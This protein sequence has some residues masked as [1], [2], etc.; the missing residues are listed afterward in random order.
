MQ[1][2]HLFASA[3]LTAITIASVSAH[4][5][6]I[7]NQPQDV[8]NPDVVLPQLNGTLY[9]SCPYFLNYDH[10]TVPQAPVNASVFDRFGNFLFPLFVALR[11]PGA[12]LI[13]PTNDAAIASF[14]FVLPDW[15]IT[16]GY[17][18]VVVGVFWDDRFKW[19]N[20]YLIASGQCGNVQGDPHVRTLDGLTATYLSCGDYT[21]LEHVEPAYGLQ[22]QARHCLRDGF[23]SSTCAIAVR[24]SAGADVFE[25]YTMDTTAVLV[26]N[27]IQRK[28]HTA[29]V[30]ITAKDI[31]VTRKATSFIIKCE[32]SGFVV[33]AH[34]REAE[35]ALYLD[36]AV[37]LPDSFYA[38]TRGLMGSW[39]GDRENDLMTRDGAVWNEGHGLDYVSAIEHPGIEDIER[40]W[41]V[42]GEDN[43]FTMNRVE[44]KADCSSK[45]SLHKAAMFSSFADVNDKMHT[46]ARRTCETAGLQGAFLN[47]CVFDYIASKGSEQFVKNAMENA[48]VYG[49][50]AGSHSTA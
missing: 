27:G 41:L 6:T 28:A 8:V 11:S 20:S 7:S 48:K 18:S 16:Q 34:M 3:L 49:G 13:N 25:L 42:D 43:L 5:Y 9:T 30:V 35:S 14:E 24:C 32:S 26:L 15:L 4:L 2:A 23:G 50:Q 21:L 38:K 10:A 17:K 33:T 22:F 12:P 29:N 47:T 44:S 46:I 45:S 1:T 19:R 39:D 40:S 31:T 37:R 36:T